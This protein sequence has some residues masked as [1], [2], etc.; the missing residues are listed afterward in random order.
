MIEVM[1]DLGFSPMETPRYIWGNCIV[2]MDMCILSEKERGDCVRAKRKI[3]WI[4]SMLYL[5]ILL[6]N[7]KGRTGCFSM[8]VTQ[9]R[10]TTYIYV[11]LVLCIF[12]VCVSEIFYVFHCSVIYNFITILTTHIN[13]YMYCKKGVPYFNL[14]CELDEGWV[15]ETNIIY[16]KGRMDRSAW[17]WSMVHDLIEDKL[18]WCICKSKYE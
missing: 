3:E 14:N 9:I 15:R 12:F 10:W 16:V 8:D 1:F 7:I 17:Y 13:I 4:R 6:D 18:M 5:F 11:S 2:A